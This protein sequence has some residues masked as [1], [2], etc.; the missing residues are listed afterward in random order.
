MAR[1]IAARSWACGLLAVV[2]GTLACIYGQVTT[3][4]SAAATERTWLF[5]W[6]G[7]CGIGLVF[8]WP[9]FKQR[10]HEIAVLC[11]LSFLIRM[12][13]LPTAPSDDMYRYVWE[14]SLVRAGIS[15]YAQTADAEEWVPLRDENWQRMNHLDQ[16]TAYPPLAQLTFAAIGWL[17]D[18]PQTLKLFFALM[19]VLVVVGLVRILCL[20]RMP[21]RWAGFYAF[22]PI[23]LIAFAAEGHFD[24]L[25]V[26]AM[27]ATLWCLLENKPRWAWCCLGLAVQFKFVALILL[28]FLLKRTRW[29]SVWPFFVACLVPALP[30]FTTLPGWFMGL[31]QFAAHHSFNGCVHGILLEVT[32]ERV[33]ANISV[34]IIFIGVIGWRLCSRRAY[35]DFIDDAIWAF[36]AL[37]VLAPTVHFWYL[38]WIWPWLVLRPSPAWLVL[39]LSQAWY[40]GVW[41]GFAQTGVWELSW[42]EQVGVWGPFVV[43]GLYEGRRVV[44]RKYG[45]SSATD[46]AAEPTVS[47]VIPTFNAGPLLATCL[48][49]IR[50]GLRQPTEI[51]VAD[52]GSTD[53]TA[54]VAQ[55]GNVRFIRAPKGRGAQIRAGVLTARSDVVLVL[56]AD[57]C[58]GVHALSKLIEFKQTNPDV[59]GGALGQRFASCG[60][61]LLLIELLNEARATLKGSSFGDQGQFF[62]RAFA[63][64][65]DGFP[66]IP[67]MEDVEMGQRLLQHGRVVYLGE[68]LRV[69]ASKWQRQGW[70]QRFSTVVLLLIRYHLARTFFS[71]KIERITAELYARYYR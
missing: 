65:A 55:A 38:T 5:L 10:S 20:K 44:T 14:G 13:L 43:V 24:V 22:S 4:H 9:A 36:G 11:V 7:L 50:Q 59:I 48:A 2:T 71:K 56:H 45:R 51:I 3:T 27:V 35:G 30:F 23:P 6:I 47:V 61:G 31:S 62:D 26:A 70:W 34:A 53:T 29:E 12:F 33:W 67:L 52:G 64:S 68:E 25:L 37:L 8:C 42:L 15:P 58:M 18:S 16:L 28:P 60:L 46:I 69:S 39:G 40:F 63:S 54:A 41:R 66:A 57:T 32:G 49:S 1:D 17:D 19:D 21:I